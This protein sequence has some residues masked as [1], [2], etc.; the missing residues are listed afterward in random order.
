MKRGGVR[1]TITLA[2]VLYAL[3]LV[4]SGHYTPFLLTLGAISTGLAVYV[5]LRMELVD[6]EG[7]AVI[8]LTRRI[9]TYIPF[10]IREIV[11][12]NIAV[13]K[14]VWS[15]SLPIRPI[16]MRVRSRQRS[17][18]GRVIF[19]NSITIT[20]GT[21]TLAIVGQ[22]LFVHALDG[23]AA[24]DLSEGEMNKKVAELERGGVTS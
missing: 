14:I 18:L 22:T 10:L 1:E 16:I 3:W 24:A 17:D 21:V 2:I 8:H 6:H 20:P 23:D 15:P 12:S 19:G 7:L 13:A 11:L 5:A 9:W 4:L